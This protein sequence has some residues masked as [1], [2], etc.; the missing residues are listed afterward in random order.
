M[1][2]GDN[3]T[4]SFNTYFEP[5]EVN[6]QIG[7]V[8]ISDGLEENSGIYTASTADNF[9]L[10]FTNLDTSLFRDG[11]IHVYFELNVPP[12]PLPGPFT[13]TS[14]ATNPDTDGSFSLQWTASVD[15]DNYSVYQD[16][17]LLNNGI[18]NLYY[19]ITISVNDTYDFKVIACNVNGE[20]ESNE[21][22]VI[23]AIPPEEPN[24]TPDLI[25]GFNPLIVIGIIG[26]ISTV[27]AIVIR[28]KLDH[29]N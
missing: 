4:W 19:P 27:S 10:V 15:S 2:A 13:L 5:F 21:I 8:E 14:T 25:P 3:L 28:K 1:V 11:F 18:T 29:L 23:V 24:L 17:V 7:G 6:F 26:S 22:I 16:S 9:L 12:P 20:T